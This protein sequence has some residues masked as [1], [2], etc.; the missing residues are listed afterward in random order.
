MTRVNPGDCQFD[1]HVTGDLRDTDVTPVNPGDCLFGNVQVNA[2]NGGYDNRTGQQDV[3]VDL[4]GGGSVCVPAGQELIY[5]E[6][7]DGRVGYTL[8]NASTCQQAAWTPQAQPAAQPGGYVIVRRN[9]NRNDGPNVTTGQG[10]TNVLSTGWDNDETRHQ[11]RQLAAAV[12]AGTESLAGGVVTALKVEAAVVGAVLAAPALGA[13]FGS[14]VLWAAGAG[15]VAWQFGTACDA[16]SGA[17]QT[18]SQCVW[19]ALWD[20]TGVS[21]LYSSYTDRDIMTDAGLGLTPYQRGSMAMGGLGQAVGTVAMV[22]GAVNEFGGWLGGLAGADAAEEAEALAG[23]GWLAG[24][25]WP[26]VSSATC[27]KCPPAREVRA[28]PGQ[29]PAAFPS[30]VSRTRPESP[31]A[32]TGRAAGSR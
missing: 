21:G 9:A 31:R 27:R 26:P 23:A 3:R 10:I 22:G 32:L 24:P 4:P 16:R 28:A 30:R 17:H 29:D 5:Y 2:E 7:E 19:G 8:G 18:T 15:T 12:E 13:V 20:T 25:T 14:S 1:W 11:A 6:Y